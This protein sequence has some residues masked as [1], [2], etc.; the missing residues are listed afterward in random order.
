MQNAAYEMR[1]SD[2]S[3]DVRSSDLL[4]LDRLERPG[5]RGIDIG[6]EAD[7]EHPLPGLRRRRL[8]HLRGAAVAGD[9]AEQPVERHRGIGSADHHRRDAHQCQRKPPVPPVAAAFSHGS[10][11]THADDGNKEHHH[12]EAE[13]SEEHTSELQSLMRISYAVFCLKK[14]KTQK[15]Q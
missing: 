9:L 4:A 12:H 7:V 8:G 15:Y 1:I 10:A 14:N 5:Q 2:W 13:R 11:S 3:S 6:V